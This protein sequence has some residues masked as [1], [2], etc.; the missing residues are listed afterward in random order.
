MCAY[1]ITV[2]LCI[3]VLL[4]TH[5]EENINKYMSKH[6]YRIYVINVV[7]YFIRNKVFTDLIKCPQKT[8]SLK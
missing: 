3:R 4:D 8:E 6:F 5:S 7:L 1:I 2:R